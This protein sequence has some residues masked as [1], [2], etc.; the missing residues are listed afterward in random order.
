MIPALTLTPQVGK[1]CSEPLLC[2]ASLSKHRIRACTAVSSGR[3]PFLHSGQRFTEQLFVSSACGHELYVKG[4][5]VLVLRSDQSH[6]KKPEK[7]PNY[8]NCP[9][10]PK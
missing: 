5:S 7:W 3:H 4:F 6:V 1:G 10:Q 8:P 2:P 9:L